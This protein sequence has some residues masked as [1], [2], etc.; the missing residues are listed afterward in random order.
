MV[1]GEIRTRGIE[2]VSK[3]IAA[4]EQRRGEIGF[5]D[6]QY[7]HGVMPCALADTVQRFLIIA[8]T[9]SC[10]LLHA[11]IMPI[12]SWSSPLKHHRECALGWIQGSSR[13]QSSPRLTWTLLPGR[14]RSMRVDHCPENLPGALALVTDDLRLVQTLCYADN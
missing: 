6:Y 3:I 10:R 9:M 1:E 13:Y 2:V 7:V 5:L 11:Q 8:D 14:S 12:P 4:A